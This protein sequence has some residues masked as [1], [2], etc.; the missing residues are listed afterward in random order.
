MFHFNNTEEL[1]KFICSEFI[2]T[3]EAAHIL[4]CSRQ[5]IDQL[6]KEQKLI[7]VKILNRNK[8]FYKPDILARK[9]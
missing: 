7:P 4:G 3:T 8:L 5:Y 1:K 9:N 6:V 2:E